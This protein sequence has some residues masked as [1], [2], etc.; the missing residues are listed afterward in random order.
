MPGRVQVWGHV[1]MHLHFGV[2]STQRQGMWHKV[3]Y[4][5]FLGNQGAQ[6]GIWFA[7]RRESRQGPHCHAGLHWN[8]RLLWRSLW[9][10]LMGPGK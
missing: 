7:C 9:A 6:Q 10:S 8:P 5:D 1:P 2:G 4:R 3:T